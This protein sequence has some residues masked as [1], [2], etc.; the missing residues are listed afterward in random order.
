MV[1]SPAMPRGQ[2]QQ[3]HQNPIPARKAPL[4]PPGQLTIASVGTGRCTEVE[5]P[6]ILPNREGVRIQIPSANHA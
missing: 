5:S 4:V 6:E 2:F 1:L 3:A